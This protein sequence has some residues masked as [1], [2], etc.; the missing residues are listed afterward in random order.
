MTSIAIHIP[1]H[2]AVRLDRVAE[3]RHMSREQLVRELLAGV[4][5]R[6]TERVASELR[7]IRW[8]NSWQTDGQHRTA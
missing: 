5:D 1:D 2:L 8:R 7:R 6:E 4:V 3:Q